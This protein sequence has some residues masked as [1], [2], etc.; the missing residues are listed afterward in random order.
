MTEDSHRT[1]GASY[2]AAG[3]DIAAGDRAMAQVRDVTFERTDD[4]AAVLLVSDR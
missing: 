1:A 4:V 2:A 3:V